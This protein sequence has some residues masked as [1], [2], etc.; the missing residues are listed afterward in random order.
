M[1]VH[2]SVKISHIDMLCG[3]ATAHPEMAFHTAMHL[4]NL[5]CVSEHLPVRDYAGEH[6]VALCAKLPA[7]QQN[8][9]MIDLIR[10]LETGRE[11]VSRYIPKFL[12][13]M[14][15]QLPDSAFDECLQSLAELVHSDNTLAAMAALTTLAVVLA[16]QAGSE[17]VTEQVFGLLLTGVAR[18]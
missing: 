17:A 14:L 1:A 16:N 6:L 5:L 10:E 8:E 9:L 13:R 3:N 12:G 7:D 11:E 18:F 2:W 15:C 4:S